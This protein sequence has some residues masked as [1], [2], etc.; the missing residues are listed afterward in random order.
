MFETPPRCLFYLLAAW[1]ER[2]PDPDE[3]VIWRFS[4]EDART[5]QRR[6]FADLQAL[7]AALQQEMAEDRQR[8]EE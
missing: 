6:G 5:R 4:L 2:H 7:V 3:P 1:E 8:R